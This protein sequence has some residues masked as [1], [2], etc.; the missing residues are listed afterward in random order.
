MLRWLDAGRSAKDENA[1]E[2]ATENAADERKATPE[3]YGFRAVYVF[4][5]D[6]T[7]GKEL[8]SLSDVRG[9][10]TGFKERLIEYVAAQGIKLSYS[11]KIA[12]A[13]G[14]SSGK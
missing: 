10:V 7:E 5:V 8:P 12:P 13:K 11:E 14:L 2:I 4:D 3:L 6:Q 1:T 9:D